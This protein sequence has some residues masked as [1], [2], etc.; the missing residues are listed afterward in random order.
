[1][2]TK[3]SE[4][5]ARSWDIQHHFEM[6]DLSHNGHS[7]EWGGWFHRLITLK[8]NSLKSNWFQCFISLTILPV[9]SWKDVSFPSNSQA[10]VHTC[11]WFGY[12]H[13]NKLLLLLLL[14]RQRITDS[15]NFNKS[16]RRYHWN[17]SAWYFKRYLRLNWWR[18]QHTSCCLRL[19]CIC[20]FWHCWTCCATKPS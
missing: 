10:N 13:A 12:C 18:P 2:A 16:R 17:R 14:N 1:M 4:S 7:S 19:T 3:L 8:K 6:V 11:N 9:V 5:V 20:S 15:P